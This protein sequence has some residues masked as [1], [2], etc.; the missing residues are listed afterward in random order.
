M[1]L[2]VSAV[3][4]K[5][6]RYPLI[7]SITASPYPLRHMYGIS[8]INQNVHRMYGQHQ[9]KRS[10]KHGYK[11]PGTA[12]RRRYRIFETPGKRSHQNGDTEELGRENTTITCR[13]IEGMTH[14]YFNTAG[15]NPWRNINFSF[16]YMIPWTKKQWKIEKKAVVSNT[17]SNPEADRDSRL[18][19]CIRHQTK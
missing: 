7:E 13:T 8:S 15:M 3:Y 1:A 19:P 9:K 10:A 16:T 18:T 11:S 12:R 4:E 2:K 5:R 17:V 6:W 14:K